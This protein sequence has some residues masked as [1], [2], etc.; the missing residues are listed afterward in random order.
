MARKEK[1]SEKKV[2]KFV[3]VKEP[4]DWMDELLKK[5]GR[6]DEIK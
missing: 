5:E 3:P 4:I 6:G 2:H 1:K